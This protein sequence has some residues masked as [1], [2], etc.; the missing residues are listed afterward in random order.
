MDHSTAHAAHS[1]DLPFS[2]EEIKALHDD[3]KRAATFVVGLMLGIFVVG[4][5]LYTIIAIG[6]TS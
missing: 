5:I 1:D 6:A 4:V 2:E 3:D